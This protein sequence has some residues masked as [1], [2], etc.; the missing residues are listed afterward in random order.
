MIVFEFLKTGVIE[1][2]AIVEKFWWGRFGQPL[3]RKH[4]H[5]LG[6][7]YEHGAMSNS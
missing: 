7:K 6:Y 1:L 3:A 4:R 5:G 2:N